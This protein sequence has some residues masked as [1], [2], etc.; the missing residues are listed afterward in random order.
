MRVFAAQKLCA[1]GD[2]YGRQLLFRYLDDRDWTLRAM[3]A[4]GIGEWGD[5]DDYYNLLNRVNGESYDFVR[6][7]L[8]L[9]LLKMSK[10]FPA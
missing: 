9:A 10:R 4:Y 8:C 6:T 5:R 2:P 1:V 3:A 7:E